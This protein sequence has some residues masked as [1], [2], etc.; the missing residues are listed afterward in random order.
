[1]MNR[2]KYLNQNQQDWLIRR[3]DKRQDAHVL[4]GFPEGAILFS[5][6]DWETPR[7]AQYYRKNAQPYKRILDSRFLERRKESRAR[8]MTTKNRKI[9]VT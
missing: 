3:Y 6:R 8:A 5:H 1:M 4:V 7:A 9:A 2:N